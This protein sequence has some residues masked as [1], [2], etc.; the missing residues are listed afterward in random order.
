MMISK[1]WLNPKVGSVCFFEPVNSIFPAHHK[2][3]TGHSYLK[4]C[5]QAFEKHGVS[6]GN[7]PRNI[8]PGMR[9]FLI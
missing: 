2:L 6:E 4:E 5:A 3:Q 1:L 7:Y 9:V 8:Y